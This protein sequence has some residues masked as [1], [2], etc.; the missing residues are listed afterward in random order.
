MAELNEPQARAVAHAEGPLLV[1][2]GAGSGKTRVI[3]YRVANLLAEHRVPPYRI[4]AVTFTNKAAG[5]L[6][7][8]LDQ[9]AGEDV[10]RDLWIGTFHAVCARLLRR[11]HAEVGLER[12]FVIYDA[13]DQKAV[14]SRVLKEMGLD[15]KR[16]PPKLALSLIHAEKREAR[17]PRDVDVSRGGFDDTMVEVYE[18]YQRALA[19]A[20]AVDFDDLILHMMRIAEDPH[21]PAGRELR[22]RFEHVLVDEFQDTNAIQYRLVRALAAQRRNLCVV[23]DDDQSIYRWRGA[24][25]RLIRGFQR[26][27]PD[28]MVVKLEQ[29][30]RST[31][32][33]VRAALGVIEP[34]LEREP[35]KLWTSAEDGEAVRV[36]AVRDERD[37]A[38]FVARTVAQEL[39]RG[40]SASDMAIFYRVHAQS[41]SLEEAFRVENLP[42]QIVGGMKFFERAEVKDLVAYLRLIENPRSDADLMRIINVPTRGI[43]GKTV[44]RLLDTAARRGTSGYDAIDAALEGKTLGTAAKKKLSAFRDMIEELRSAANEL[45]PHELAGRVLEESGY[46]RVLREEDTAESDARLEN[47]E[48]L[49]S[50]IQ[51]Y[52]QDAEEAGEPATL[53]GY[54]ERVSLISAV[55]T[56]Q[57]VPS[58]SLM[59]V[60]SAKGLEFDVVLL[61]GMEEEIFPYRGLDANEP[62][63][64]DEERRLAYVAITR[65]RQRLY[66][67]HAGMR[68]IFG[69]TRY[70]SPS[71]FLEDLPEQ[72]VVRE[73]SAWGGA[74]PA[75]ASPRRGA[76]MT[77]SPA[78]WRSSGVEI[79]AQPAQPALSP[80]QRVV[81]TD[82]FDDIPPHEPGRVVHPG[83]PVFHKRFGDGVVERVKV[84]VKPTVVARFPG[85]GTRRI[86]AQFLEFQ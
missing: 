69:Q 38:D 15:D 60:H 44:E 36:R 51:E 34:A 56:M 54:L 73:G 30:Y 5:E 67:S 35:K 53:G 29:N 1:F 71:R 40:T 31:A 27:F 58:V 49:L 21:S 55:D 57:D 41:R 13:S 22:G 78:R 25:V 85:F 32:N 50:S 16:L 8:R 77:I 3:T 33:I 42:Y 86:L 7:E 4:L 84:G 26:D 75:Y 59:T 43:G 48:E 20:N 83:D 70:L 9:L 82:A 17:G 65:A 18:R 19:T 24:D 45:S 12:Q 11:Y 66:I 37:E 74:R 10:T 63:E 79:P 62:E 23:G 72:G 28:T 76:D 64:L 39:G 61:T 52:E 2:A 47:L 68:M 46:R 81:D 80:G 14:V 6:R